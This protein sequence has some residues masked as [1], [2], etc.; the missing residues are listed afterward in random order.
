MQLKNMLFKLRAKHI[1]NNINIDIDVNINVDIDR[2][3]DN[4][5]ILTSKGFIRTYI[6]LCS[7]QRRYPK[8][9]FGIKR[10]NS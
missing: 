1:N 4:K 3:I 8:A 9:F 2:V 10:W 6:T 5:W 7:I